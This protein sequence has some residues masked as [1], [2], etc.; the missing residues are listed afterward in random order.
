MFTGENKMKRIPKDEKGFTL[1]ELVLIVGIIGILTVIAVPT[2]LGYQAKTKQSE[3][4]VNLAGIF[5]SETAYFVEKG[6]YGSTLDSISFALA[7]K[8]AYYDF[9][10]E[11]P[12]GASPHLSWGDN[13]WW[14]VHGTPGNGPQSGMIINLDYLPGVSQLAF[15]AL[16]A[17]NV[18]SGSSTCDTWTINSDMALTNQWSA[19]ND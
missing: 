2:F 7:G 13:A 6:F 10:L 14:G 8:P 12:S 16:A 9:T 1:L 5:G 3:A 11:A 19:L 4:K 17:G 15:T 18:T